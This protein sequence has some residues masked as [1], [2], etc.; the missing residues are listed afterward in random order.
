MKLRKVASDGNTTTT[1][2]AGSFVYKDGNLEF[3]HMA[4]GYAEPNSLGGFDYIYQYKDHLGNVRLSYS[5]IDGNGSIDPSTEILSE[6]NFYP[7]GLEHRG[8]NNVVSANA[9]SQAEKWKFQ[10][11]E[12]QEELGLNWI[13]FKYRN[14]DPAIARFFNVDPLAEDYVYNGVY[15][16]AEN[17]VIDG[18]ELEGLEWKSIKDEDNGNTKLQLTVQL[19]NDAGLTDKQLTKLKTSITE[20]FTESYSNSDAN[21]SAEL[22]IQDVTEAKGDFLVTLNEQ[23][24][25]PVKDKDGNVVGKKY[26]G[27]KAGAIGKTQENNF[28]VTAKRDGS[29]RSNSD[30]A[31]SFSHEAGHTAGLRHPWDPKNAIMGIKQGAT[32]VTAKTVKSNL[33]NSGAN[34]VKA[35]RSSSGT[36]LTKEQLKSIDKLVRSQ[37]N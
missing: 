21:I 22:V 1:D 10:G 12:H 29:K 4:E 13:S 8:Y 19:Y 27:G 7:F 36:K 33:M 11:Q 6:K 26:R 35:N 23:T 28:E 14:Y 37:Q 34:K 16:F 24:S 5:D 20:Q 25:K 2:Y 9:N 3:M 15:N 18:I 31:R 30:I 17:R 32:G